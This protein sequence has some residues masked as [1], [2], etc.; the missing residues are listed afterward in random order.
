MPTIAA[1]KLTSL[2]FAIVRAMGSTQGEADEVARHLVGAN[3]AGH[4]LHGVGMI[5]TYVRILKLGLLVP[6]QEIETVSDGG[7]VLVLDARRGFGQTMAAEAMRRA[8]ARARETG[9]CVMALR[10]SAH[11]GRIGTYGE[12][13]AAADMTSIHF[14]NVADHQPWQAPWGCSDARLGTNPFCAAVPG[15]DGRPALVLDMAT[16]AIAFGKA[17][18]ARNKGVPVPEGVLIDPA[19]KPTTDPRA[20][21]DDHR[22]ALLAFGL[23]KGS[24]LAVMCEILGAALI[25][26]QTITQDKK[27]GVVNN[28]LSIVID[29][30]RFGTM[31]AIRSE[32]ESVKAWIKASPPAPGFDEVLLPG[33]PE[34]RSRAK[35]LALGIPVDETSFAEILAAGEAVGPGEVGARSALAELRP[36]ERVDCVVIGAGVVGLAVARRLAMAGRE[37]IVLEKEPMIGTETS[38][39][40]SEVIHAGIYYPKGS[41]K[42]R[43]CIEGKRF[44]YDYCEARGVPHRRCGK[45]IVA[46]SD[47]QNATLETIKANARAIG[48]P[49]LELWTAEQAMALEP[50]LRCTAALWSPTTGIID[51][52]GLMLAYQGDAEDHG[53]MLAFNAPL[54]RAR[55]TGEGI[56]LEVGGDEPM[57]LLARTVV[58]SAG[59]H[60]PGLARRFEGLDPAR[61]CPAPITARA[62]TSPCP[63][64]RPSGGSSTRCRSMRASACT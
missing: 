59:L 57:Q 62:T 53:A 3:L 49:D 33:E 44:L 4:D 46:T 21:V 13:C 12:Q 42:A 56:E 8:V 36:M 11:V 22:G 20:L 15:E 2:T 40:N 35:R 37:V 50:H 55:V 38:S 61:L 26:G 52:H 58:N 63:A 29:S 27:D 9:A 5:P 10:N 32:I 30:R 43:A 1:D 16:S 48:M 18:V 51:S 47:A 64:S 28:L 23:H 7:A 60:A 45:L 41:L 19:G 17:R 31:D 54:D 24:G 14:V 34:Q 6:N 39:R 25:G